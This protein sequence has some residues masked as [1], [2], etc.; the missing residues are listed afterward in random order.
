MW[1]EGPK[2]TETMKRFRK[3][4]VKCAVT[5]HQ[6]AVKMGQSPLPCCTTWSFWTHRHLRIDFPMQEMGPS[7]QYVNCWPT[8]LALFPPANRYCYAAWTAWFGSFVSLKDR[9]L[10][11]F[12]KLCKKKSP[13]DDILFFYFYGWSQK[14]LSIAV[15]W[16]KCDVSWAALWLAPLVGTVF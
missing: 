2:M 9:F 1:Y 10:R 12:A 14:L 13:W 3:S 7:G 4:F 8:S 15:S 16:Y 11:N 6:G 5:C